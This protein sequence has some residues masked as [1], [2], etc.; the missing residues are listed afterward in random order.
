M[1][2]CPACCACSE[3]ALYELLAAVEPNIVD[4]RV[5]KDKYTGEPC[6]VRTAAASAICQ[7]WQAVWNAV[8]ACML[9]CYVPA[10]LLVRDLDR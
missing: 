6:H 3:E 1:K 9:P 4:M 5:I 10:R 2:F 7:Q 8:G